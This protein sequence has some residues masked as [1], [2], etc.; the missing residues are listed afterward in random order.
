MTQSI[1]GSTCFSFETIPNPNSNVELKF[2]FPSHPA[3]ILHSR[4]RSSRAE[5][6]AEENR[7]GRRSAAGDEGGGAGAAARGGAGLRREAPLQ[8]GHLPRRQG[9]HGHGGPWRHLHAR[10]GTLP[11]PP[12]PPRAPPPQ[13]FP[14]APRPPVQIPRRQ[15]SRKKAAEH[16]PSSPPPAAAPPPP[17]LS[18]RFIPSSTPHACQYGPRVLLLAVWIAGRPWVSIH[19]PQLS[20][21]RQAFW[22]STLAKHLAGIFS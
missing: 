22:A 9:G 8:V 2:R 14:P 19:Y 18:R 10:A 17:S 21:F 5:S 16:P 1:A 12:I 6:Q 15:V 7:R 4:R 11:R 13:Q 3:H 20:T